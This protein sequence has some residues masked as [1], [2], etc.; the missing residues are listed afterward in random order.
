M[1][2]GATPKA[3][4]V[5]W[6]YLDAGYTVR[7]RRGEP[8]AVVFRGDQMANHGNIG[9]LDTIAVPPSGWSDLAALRQ[10]GSGGCA[11]RSGPPCPHPHAVHE[12]DAMGLASADDPHDV[13]LMDDRGAG[14]DDRGTE[15]DDSRHR[16]CRA[17]RSVRSRGSCSRCDSPFHARFT[18]C[19]A[20][21]S[22]AGSRASSH[23]CPV[24]ATMPTSAW[25]NSPAT[26]VS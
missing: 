4:P 9:V 21:S 26:A 14:L 18:R 2:G 7:W 23:H 15:L 17:Q 11:N 13:E 24:S 19:A 5:G 25:L 1:S 8:V 3:A 6:V 12:V 22:L 16:A 20:T 10:V